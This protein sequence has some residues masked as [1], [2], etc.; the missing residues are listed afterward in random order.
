MS[1]EARPLIS[2]GLQRCLPVWLP[3]A[4]G[5]REGFLEKEKEKGVGGSNPRERE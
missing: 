1:G 2:P 5:V 4:S 3:R